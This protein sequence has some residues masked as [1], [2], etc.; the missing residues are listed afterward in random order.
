MGSEELTNG[1]YNWGR[2]E[3]VNVKR[4]ALNETM[5]LYSVSPF[6]SDR[7]TKPEFPALK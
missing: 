4:M 7:L 3:R 6:R 2:E 5:V 1:K